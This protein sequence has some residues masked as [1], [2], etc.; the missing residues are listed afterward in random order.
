MHG[1]QNLKKKIILPFFQERLFNSSFAERPKFVVQISIN[2]M[3][4]H[5]IQTKVSHPVVCEN[6]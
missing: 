3:K 5:Y 6:R 1:Q 4:T 2:S